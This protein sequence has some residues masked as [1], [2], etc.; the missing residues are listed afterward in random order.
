MKNINSAR[1]EFLYLILSFLD[2]YF[3]KIQKGAVFTY[4]TLN[5]APFPSFFGGLKLAPH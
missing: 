3:R 1:K 4:T 5:I 2:S